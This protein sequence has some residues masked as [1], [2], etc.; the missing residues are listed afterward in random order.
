MAINSAPR[1]EGLEREVAR[2]LQLVVEL[3]EAEGVGLGDILVEH[4]REDGARREDSRVPEDEQPVVQRDRPEV[5]DGG[6]DELRRREK[7]GE[8][9][10]KV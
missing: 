10:R 8:G 7:V 3:G 4:E 6:E 1:E 9:E 5:E 2:L